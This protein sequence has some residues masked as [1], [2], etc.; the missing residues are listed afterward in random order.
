MIRTLLSLLSLSL[1]FCCCNSGEKK[2]PITDAE[3]A[4][5][6]IR[7]L[8]DNDFK[9]A[10]RYLLTDNENEQTM[11][12]VEQKMKTFSKEELS[13]YKNA[14]IIIN[15]ISTLVNDSITIVN[16][17]NTYKPTIKNKV[18]LVRKNGQW[19]IDFKYTFSGNL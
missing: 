18:K 19:L 15:E 4:G 17:S 5:A 12:M 2:Q 7:A 8:L 10:H 1:L 3:V 13:S 6:F 14:E 9:Q 11:D 16:Y